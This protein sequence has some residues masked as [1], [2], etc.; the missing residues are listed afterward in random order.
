MFRAHKVIM[1]LTHLPKAGGKG[2]WNIKFNDFFVQMGQ[3]GVPLEELSIVSEVAD[4][5]VTELINRYVLDEPV[6]Q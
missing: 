4:E 5:R 6:P 1:E 2:F 3:A